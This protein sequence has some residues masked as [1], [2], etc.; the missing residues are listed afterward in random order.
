MLHKRTA[1]VN[2]VKTKAMTIGSNLQIGDS[3]YVHAYARVL[4]VQREQQLFF[5]N[6]GAFSHHVF[7]MPLPDEPA[8]EQITFESIHLNPM[9]KVDTIDITSVS[10][11]RSFISATAETWFWNPGLKTSDSS[12]KKDA[13]K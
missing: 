4:A 7:K 8:E 3:A 9:I 12:G 1:I 10:P 13:N 6:E 5:T 11:P 2:H